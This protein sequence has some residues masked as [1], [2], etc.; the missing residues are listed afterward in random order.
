MSIAA[1]LYNTLLLNRIR[2]KLDAKLRV[3][4]AGY[5]RGRGCSEHVHVLRRI[6]EGCD[7]KNLPLVA[8]FVDFKKAFDSI[9]RNI[10]FKILRHYGVPEQIT[11]AIRLLYEGTRSA[12]IIDGQ[13][14]DVFDVITGV[15]QGDVLAPYLFIVVIDWVMIN[16]NIDD[17]GFITHK[18]QSSRFTEEKVGDLEY[19]DDIGLLENEVDNAQRQLDALAGVAKE[20][21]LGINID[22]TKV[23]TK[24]IEPKPEIKLDETVLEVVDDFQY[25]GAW[26]N[27]TMKDFKHRRAKAW[28]AFWKLKRI[29]DS[30]ADI[31]L[32]IKF[33][34]ASVLSVLLYATETYVINAA[35]QNQI[36]AFQTQCL[37]IIL[38]ISKDEH[39]RNDY[40]YEQTNTKPLMQR[41]T[42]TQ[43]SFLGHSIR[44]NKN[45]LIQQYYLYVPKHGQ[46]SRGRQ[47]TTYQQHIAKTIYDDAMIEEKVMREAASDRV[48]WRKVVK[49]AS[50][51]SDNG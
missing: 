29:W 2:D 24:N 11:N 14:T 15:L 30:N 22:K 44:R 10:M 31:K 23:L 47:K 12:V 27:D 46:R 51:F 5:R 39:V 8:V 6:F 33:F 45:Y 19:V 37:R 20:V 35:L 21:G 36:N 7:L 32:K 13:I 4:Q 43:L 41:V 3:N 38:N 28:T 40:I 42:K 49:V 50:R 26:V 16:A 1:K 48:A 17:L 25:L 9:D 18:R 34:N